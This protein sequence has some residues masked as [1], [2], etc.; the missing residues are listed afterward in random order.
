MKYIA[1]LILTITASSL[2]AQGV[3]YSLE[4]LNLNSSGNQIVPYQFN[5]DLLKGH[6]YHIDQWNVGSF[7][8][9]SSIV[10]TDVPMKFDS[11]SGFLAI[12][13]EQDSVFMKPAV[14]TEF[15][16]SVNGMPYLFKNGYFEYDLKIKPESYLMVI[17]EGTWSIYVE[18]RKVY[19]KANYDAVFNTGS[20]FDELVEANRYLVKRP[21]NSW[22]EIVPSRRTV[23]RL[24]G[25]NSDE[26]AD[27]VRLNRLTYTKDVDLARIFEHASSLVQN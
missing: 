23:L 24:F 14:V 4:Q 6:P 15:Q 25:R 18:T 20:R 12:R 2:H 11:Y 17:S 13:F 27:Y 9:S 8:T 5:Y 7:R 21:D 1:V 19:K 10:F 26:V 22:I 16:Y 3:G